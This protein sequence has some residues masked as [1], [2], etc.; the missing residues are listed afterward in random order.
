MLQRQCP[1]FGCSSDLQRRSLQFAVVWLQ[2][3][4]RMEKQII[5]V[6]AEPQEVLN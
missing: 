1:S 4:K 2:L 6:F 3:A 5:A